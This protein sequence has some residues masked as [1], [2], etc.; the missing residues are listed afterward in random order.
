MYIVK[1][2]GR[3]GVIYKEGDR[4]VQI[5]AEMLSG[6][7]DLVIYSEGIKAWQ[8]PHDDEII[9]TEE[10]KNII[11]NITKYLEEKGLSIEWE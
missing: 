6:S 1:F 2:R 11:V 9:S 10:K 8:P 5:E 7:I 4:S 3:S